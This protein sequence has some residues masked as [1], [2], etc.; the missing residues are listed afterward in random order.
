MKANPGKY[1]RLLSGNDSSKITIEN[2]TI[3]SKCEKLLGI[4]IDSNLNFKENIE[5]LCKK[6]SQ[7]INALSKLASLMNFAQKRLTMNSFVSCHFSNF[8]VVWMFH[9]RKLNAHI[10]RFHERALRVV[11]KDFDPSFE[12]L[13]RRDSPKALHQRN[14]QKVMIKIFDVKTGIAQ[15]MMKGV[16]EFVDVSYNLTNQSKC[17]RIISCT[18]RYGIEATS[19]IGPK[20][21]DQVHTEIK[22][23]KSLEE[24]KARIKSWIPKKLS[25]QDM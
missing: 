19:S 16:F 6:A 22:N 14:L 20:L 15:E 5:S 13:L 21:W 9:C 25:L 3:S 23:S 12:E 8:L 11:Y 2:E 10:N 18:E 4:K 1:H 7:K 24:F 17:S